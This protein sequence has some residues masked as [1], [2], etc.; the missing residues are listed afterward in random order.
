VIGILAVIPSDRATSPHSLV[1]QVLMT[2]GPSSWGPGELP[3][4]TSFGS[5]LHTLR[6]SKDNLLLAELARSQVQEAF[7]RHLP[8]FVLTGIDVGTSSETLTLDISFLAPPN[9]NSG[10][11][12]VVLPLPD[13]E[14]Q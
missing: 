5:S 11:T 7:H 14:A 13:R 3:W 9:Q 8:D 12:Q 4:D 2:R 10:S 6:H 1:K